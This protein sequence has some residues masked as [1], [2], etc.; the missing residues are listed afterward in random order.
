M[1]DGPDLRAV[2]GDGVPGVP[3]VPWS[4]RDVGLAIIT[5]VGGLVVSVIAL[6]LVYSVRDGDPTTGDTLFVAAVLSALMAASAWRY[7]A[8]KYRVGWRALGL[9]PPSGPGAF[10]LAAAA[11]LG[12]LVFTAGYALVIESLGVEVLAPPELPGVFLGRGRGLLASIVVLTLLAPFAEEVFFR[13][14]IYG[15]LRK[16]FPVRGAMLASA[17]IF[18]AMHGDPGVIIPI[19]VTG[20]LLAWVYERTGS[21]WP[22]V[23]AHTGQNLLALYV[24][25]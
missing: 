10:G 7:G 25:L 19:F 11:L 5:V 13:G 22:A 20:F 9:V 23:A 14:F 3:Q 18:A 17:A 8:G 21:V 12:S 1:Q 24:A 15:A 2:T 16:R 6:G 4:L